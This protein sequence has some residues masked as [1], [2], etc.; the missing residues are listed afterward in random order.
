MVKIAIQPQL[1]KYF[2]FVAKMP[3]FRTHGL[4]WREHHVIRAGNRLKADRY[5]AN[6]KFEP[7]AET[8]QAAGKRKT[9]GTEQK[10]ARAAKAGTAAGD[11]KPCS[12]GP[13]TGWET[14]VRLR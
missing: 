10:P 13:E 14:V 8:T 5:G 2:A 7:A 6:C 9:R 3:R 4:I 1:T 11:N 12:A